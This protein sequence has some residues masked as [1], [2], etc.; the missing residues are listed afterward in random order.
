MKRTRDETPGD[1]GAGPPKQVR[2]SGA[3]NERALISP[4]LTCPTEIKHHIAWYVVGPEGPCVC[5]ENVLMAKDNVQAIVPLTL[6]NQQLHTDIAVVMRMLHWAHELAR[7][8]RPGP[9][10]PPPDIDLLLNDPTDPLPGDPAGYLHLDSSRMPRQYAKALLE[11]T[12]SA[13]P[14]Q[15]KREL[16]KGLLMAYWARTHPAV[17]QLTQT[18]RL[19]LDHLPLRIMSR[20]PSLNPTLQRLGL[21]HTFPLDAREAPLHALLDFIPRMTSSLRVMF[22]L[23]LALAFGNWGSPLARAIVAYLKQRLGGGPGQQLLDQVQRWRQDF[24]DKDTNFEPELVRQVLQTLKRSPC[25][26]MEAGTRLLLKFCG[27]MTLRAA[28]TDQELVAL[29]QR[30]MNEINIE[31]DMLGILRIECFFS[32]LPADLGLAAFQGLRPRR[33][34]AFIE[35]TYGEPVL[36]YIKAVVT[37]PEN[38]IPYIHRLAALN[39]I[40]ARATDDDSEHPLLEPLNALKVFL[41]TKDPEREGTLGTSP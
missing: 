28:A 23:S 11:F 27:S 37:A 24:L 3:P 1:D 40:I 2:R 25:L 14:T 22:V 7:L 33:R 39:S 35:A 10:A 13:G 5:G 17:A 18:S 26:S 19:W 21:L 34:L 31:P 9:D 32:E 36:P 41:A 12:R 29:L 16:L 4:L 20:D 30:A 6:V 38:D 8:W 15:A